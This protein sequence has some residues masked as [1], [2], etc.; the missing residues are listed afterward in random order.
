MS[1]GDPSKWKYFEDMPFTEFLI[2]AE[3]YKDKQEERETQRRLNKR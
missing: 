3:Y 2:L 1:D